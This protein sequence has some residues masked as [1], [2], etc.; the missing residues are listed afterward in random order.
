[1]IGRGEHAE[2]IASRQDG[3]L[4]LSGNVID[5]L[6]GRRP[7]SKPFRYTARNGSCR[8]RQSAA[9]QP[10]LEPD[11]RGEHRVMRVLPPKRGAD[12]CWLSDRDRYSTRINSEERLLKPMLKE[13]ALAG[14]RLAGRAE[15]VRDLSESASST[16]QEIGA[17]AIPF[18]PRGNGAAGKLARAIGSGNVDFRASRIFRRRKRA[19]VHG[20]G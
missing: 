2:I 15:H 12:E 8:R 19:G 20:S 7:H 4:R 18:H 17:L 3:G 5:L 10:R 1:M 14:G 13:A 9:R 11:R 16:S 6:P